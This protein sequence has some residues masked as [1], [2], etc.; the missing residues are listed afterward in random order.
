[1]R[2]D[3]ARRPAARGPAAAIAL[4]ALLASPN[5]APAGEA[6]IVSASA[7]A[8]G[9]GSF[10][11]EATVRHADEGWDHY[12]DAFDVLAPDG[13]VLGTRTLAHP[14]VEE[15]PFTRSLRRVEVP[16]G[17]AEVVVRAKDSVHGHG[18]AQVTI[19]LP[20]RVTN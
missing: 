8:N 2:G 11:V 5:V 17:L 19:P 10:T 12:A 14:H 20:G 7:R 6:D 9:D 18:G 15:Q 4:C 3:A 1:M 16:D 13:T